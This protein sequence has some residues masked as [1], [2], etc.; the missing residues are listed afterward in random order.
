MSDFIMETNET[1]TSND[2]DGWL[3]GGVPNNE[4]EVQK[5][6]LK[7]RAAIMVK[8]GGCSFVRKSLNIQKVGG[9]VAVISDNIE[10]N[11]DDVIMIDIN[12]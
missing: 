12:N 4:K 1:S 6:L 8:R 3:I 9:K 10:E 7:E 2:T 11:E 5:L